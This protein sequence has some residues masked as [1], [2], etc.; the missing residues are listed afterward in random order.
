[1]QTGIYGEFVPKICSDNMAM[2]K[3]YPYRGAFAEAARRLKKHRNSVARSY[4]R[5]NPEVVVL[6]EKIIEQRKQGGSHAGQ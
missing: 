2:R 5:Q 6:V 3:K 4:K 1:M